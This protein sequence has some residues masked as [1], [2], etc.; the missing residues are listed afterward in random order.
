MKT[1]LTS[2]EIHY[3]V[4]ELEELIEG[5]IDKIYQPSKE[6]IL[7][8]FHLPNKGRKILKI[9]VGK[10][11]YL[12][13]EKE[14]QQEPPSFCMQ[15]RKHIGNARLRKI[16]QKESERIIEFEFEKKEGI[17]KLYVELFSKGN[18]ILTDDK[19]IIIMALQRQEFRDRSVKPKEEYKYPRKELN[20][21]ELKEDDLFTLIRNSKKDSIVT[22]LA[23]DLGL[24]GT[25]AEEACL[26]SGI[27]KYNMPEEFGEAEAKSLLDAIVSLTKQELDPQIVKDGQKVVDIVPFRMKVYETLE[28]QPSS[29]FNEALNKHLN[30]GSKEAKSPYERQIQKIK[31]IIERQRTHIKGMEESEENQR[32]LAEIIYENYGTINEVITEVNKASKKY[33]WEE[34][35]EKLTG[36]KIVK[37]IDAKEKKVVLEF[38]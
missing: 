36:H 20:F 9:P 22:C 24:G 21:F 16:E 25:Y 23:V 13:E 6:E 7:L 28:N 5:K 37:E 12:T 11:P 27:S 14:E 34:I 38:N 1:Q 35:K 29:S 15:M 19:N 17:K 8:Q 4:K 10:V 30:Q 32:K 31:D 18:V 3:L 26:I 33:S 2:L